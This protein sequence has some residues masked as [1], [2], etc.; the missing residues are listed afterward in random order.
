[1]LNRALLSRQDQAGRTMQAGLRTLS[2]PRVTGQPQTCPLDVDDPRD[3]GT[4]ATQEM[5]G[6]GNRRAVQDL[7]GSGPRAAGSGQVA[8]VIRV[9]VRC[10]RWS[11][12]VGSLPFHGDV[13]C[14]IRVMMM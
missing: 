13:V 3:V 11:A 9:S 8:G 10:E 1:M 2:G 14:S 5:P 6:E 7:S 4:L 12:P